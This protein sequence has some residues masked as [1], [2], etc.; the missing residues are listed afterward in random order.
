MEKSRVKP[1]RVPGVPR[2]AGSRKWSHKNHVA[3]VRVVTFICQFIRTHN[4]ETTKTVDSDGEYITEEFF[5]SPADGNQLITEFGLLGDLCQIRSLHRFL[6]GKMAYHVRSNKTIIAYTYPALYEGNDDAVFGYLADA[7]GTKAVPIGHNVPSDVVDVAAMSNLSECASQALEILKS[8]DSP[9]D[10]SPT[11]S[12][13]HM[14]SLD[15]TPYPGTPVA[16]PSSDAPDFAAL[17]ARMAKLEQ[18]VAMAMSHVEA[19]VSIVV[20]NYQNQQNASTS[21]M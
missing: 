20:Q 21:Q 13:E 7:I 2:V 11:D 1:A 5:M 14:L 17:L 19:I 10:S 15:L 18:D 6:K 12:P 3:R 16:P 9:Q 4:I 8:H